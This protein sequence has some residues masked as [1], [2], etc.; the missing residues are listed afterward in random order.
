MLIVV[1]T[2]LLGLI[3]QSRNCST[4]ISNSTYPGSS[5]YSSS[6][7]V[8]FDLDAILQRGRL[9]ALT[10][11]SSTSYFIYKGEP[12]GFEYEMLNAYARSIG[13]KLQ[14]VIAKDMDKIFSTL[15]SGEVDIVAAN[16][17][18]TQDRSKIVSFSEPLLNTRQVLVQRKPENWKRMTGQQIEK[19]MIRSTVD[20]GGKVIHVRKG[21]SFYERL[22]NLSE[23]IGSEIYV[24]PASGD[25]ET[26]QLISMVADGRIDYT[27]AD[28]NVALI[29]QSYY[30]NIDIKTA[31]S[32]PQHIA[33]A[34]R[35]NSY[36]L[37]NSINVWM[38]KEK[39]T[40]A[41]AYIFNKYFHNTLAADERIGSDFFSLTG[42]RICQYDDLI[43]TYSKRIKWD[44]RL[45]ASLIYEESHF[46]AEALSW[47]GAYGLMQM[48]PAT[49]SFYGI[50]SINATPLE[51]IRA[52][53][54]HLLRIDNFWS[55]FI[56]D[57]TERIKF[58]L[59]SYNVG[60]GH[61][62]DARN[63]ASKYGKE[64]NKWENNVAWCLLMKSNSKYFNDPLV[65]FGYCRGAEPCNYVTEI[66]LRFDH[67]CNFIK[68]RDPEKNSVAKK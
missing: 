16:L 63:L 60:L 7:P 51:S 50:D 37:E 30:P 27:I 41:Q 3:F 20:L 29:N 47:T 33:W 19:N 62:I 18:V 2:V 52:G 12:M 24:I 14:V 48:I 66:L 22:T 53:T 15:N 23:E 65:K 17:T 35:K 25:K 21:S 39:E 28:E 61:I 10:D 58:D 40:G 26:E 55:Q 11:Y 56:S 36:D 32:F 54:T 1:S 5:S 8:R 45:L 67:Y 59:A 57:K 4:G 44:W 6:Q 9:I 64:K 34:I 43:K 49:S 46:N 13:V 38:M 31:I 68:E 42:N